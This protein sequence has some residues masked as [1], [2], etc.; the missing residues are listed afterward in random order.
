MNIKEE[1][2]EGISKVI[3]ETKYYTIARMKRFDF[4]SN[5][6]VIGD[7]STVQYVSSMEEAEVY[8]RTLIPLGQDIIKN[9]IKKAQNLLNM[10]KAVLERDDIN[11]EAAIFNSI[12]Y[13]ELYGRPCVKL[14]MP[15]GYTVILGENNIK[16]KHLVNMSFKDSEI[17]A[18]ATVLSKYYNKT[19]SIIK[20][21]QAIATYTNGVEN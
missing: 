12:D 14:T 15:S 10:I 9:N 2:R 20:D 16:Y 17:E 21:G 13:Q 7:D 11:Y 4:G 5:L 3:A 1:I 18:I 8:A 6:A 19:L